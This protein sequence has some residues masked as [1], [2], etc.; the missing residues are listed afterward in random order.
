MY[1]DLKHIEKV[2]IYITII[3]NLGNYKLDD[4]DVLY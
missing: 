4:L 3:L 2:L 1:H